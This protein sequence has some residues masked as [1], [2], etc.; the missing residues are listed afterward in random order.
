MS[1]TYHTYKGTKSCKMDPKHRVSIQPTWRPEGGE[2]LFL[3]ESKTY[4]LPM[5]KV[6]TRAAYDE[7]VNRVL[8]SDKSP[9]E[10]DLLLGKLAAMC[11]EASIN[12]Q[13]KML[14][15]KETSNRV[16]IEANSDVALVGRGIHFEIWSKANHERMLEHEAGTGD[17][18]LNLF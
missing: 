17:D 14:V 1:A 3:M 2:S 5:I 6:L 16:G 8:E 10:K 9:K 18:D 7:R 11:V 4:E 12:E 13:G 15:P